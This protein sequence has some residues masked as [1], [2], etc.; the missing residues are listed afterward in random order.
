VLP[1]SCWRRSVI[2]NPQM[3]L[4]R[5]LLA[6]ATAVGLGTW[7]SC[8]WCRPLLR[9]CVGRDTWVRRCTARWCVQTGRTADSATT[10]A[11]FGWVLNSSVHWYSAPHS[12]FYGFP[13]PPPR[14]PTLFFLSFYLSFF[15]LSSSLPSAQLP[16]PPQL[17][18]TPTPP[19]HPGLLPYINNWAHIGGLVFGAVAGVVFLPTRAF[20]RW[21]RARKQTASHP[22]FYYTLPTHIGDCCL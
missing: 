18:P 21:D 19:P 15:S 12:L 1:C 22:A 16:P 10:P 3:N 7:R 2:K 20:S 5:L 6:M 14:T 8:T 11:G 4:L 9:G 17:P 13:P